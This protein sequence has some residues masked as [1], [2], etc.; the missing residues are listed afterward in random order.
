MEEVLVTAARLPGPRALLFSNVRVA[1]SSDIEELASSTVSEAITADGGVGL[2]RYGHYGALQTVA[3]RGGA[4]NEVVYLLDGVPFADP[5]VASIDQ[6]WLPFPATARLEAM[7]GGASA[8][9]GS[10]AVGGVINLVSMDAAP[11]VPSSEITVWNG[12]YGSRLVGAT[13]RRSVAGGVGVLGAYDY[14]KSDGWVTNSAYRGEKFYGKVS[15]LSGDARAEVAVFRH[16]G[17]VETPGVFP[18]SQSDDRTFLRASVAGGGERGYRFA[19][20]HSGSD[21]TY[22]S[23]GDFGDYLYRHQ[24]AIDGLQAEA[25]ARDRR[26]TASSLSAGIERKTLESSSVGDRSASDL[27]VSV[28][29]EVGSGPLRLSA[30]LRLEKNSGFG[31][32]MAPQVAAWLEGR[33]GLWLFV[34]LDRSFAY[35]T[36]NDL[37]WRGPNE[38]GDPALET[39]H[40]AG[41]EAGA[42]LQGR[43]GR[44]SAALYY[45]D[46]ED[47][48]L[49]RTG[50]PCQLIRS[51]N[52]AAVF[53][54]V[55]L[56][57]QVEPAAGVELG[58]SYWMGSATDERGAGLEYRPANVFAW[59]GRAERRLSRH[60]VCG[61]AL[62]GRRVS[63]VSTGDQYDFS[64][65][66]CLRGT[67]L[68]GY[69]S[70]AFYG[71]AALDGGRVFVRVNNLFDDR[72]PSTWGMPDLPSRSYQVG[73]GLELR[74]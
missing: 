51:T 42:L 70:A 52:V 53:K 1:D 54:G 15:R 62:S 14:L 32:E 49:W 11:A 39:E 63:R 68:P 30:S 10:G 66:V 43:L 37:F 73:L 71:Y 36:F 28:Q 17:D 4:S 2:S 60:L 18:G 57:W 24:G 20:Y 7:K 13:L 34:K 45:R 64:Q 23:H 50:E 67:G 65:W 59:H 58:F 16:A 74:D 27:F 8:L 40:S 9:Y 41:V 5:Q 26:G 22:V 19:Y 3:F 55:E 12:S 44:A 38:A 31:A 33:G 29:Q 46:L 21:Q 6:N 48:I 61:A 47:M 56:A 69:H 35:P 72:I 25:Y